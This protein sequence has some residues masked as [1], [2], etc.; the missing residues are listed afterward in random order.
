MRFTIND[1][2]PLVN[3]RTTTVPGT[4]ACPFRQTKRTH[5][6]IIRVVGP[7]LLTYLLRYNLQLYR[8]QR[9]T[10]SVRINEPKATDSQDQTRGG[11]RELRQLN[12]FHK[13]VEHDRGLDPH[14]RDV[15]DER[16]RLVRGDDVLDLV[17]HPSVVH[18]DTADPYHDNL[19]GDDAMPRRE[20]VAFVDDGPAAV[21]GLAEPAIGRDGR[22]VRHLP[23]LH[24]LAPED[25]PVA[26]VVDVR[27]YERAEEQ[28][29]AQYVNEH[30]AV[31]GNR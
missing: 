30:V 6:R 2:S 23:Q 8:L 12:R 13:R 9:I 22:V 3:K 11:V 16:L 27:A 20:D 25:P 28:V 31:S 17:P 24:E 26:K 15:L 19:P 7:L 4:S 21:D 10:S 18:V 5:P 1:I 29:Q 14:Q